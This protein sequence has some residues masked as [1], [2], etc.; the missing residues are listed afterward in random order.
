MWQKA[1]RNE[2]A[3]YEIANRPQRSDDNV[4]CRNASLED[5]CQADTLDEMRD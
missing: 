3:I 1:Y 5:I 2:I 4:L